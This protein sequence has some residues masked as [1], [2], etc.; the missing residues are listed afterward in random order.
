MHIFISDRS[1]ADERESLT[2][3]SGRKCGIQS[4]SLHH[5]QRDVGPIL[6]A[7]VAER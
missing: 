6:L 7:S 5:I 4:L 1:E 3:F 2:N